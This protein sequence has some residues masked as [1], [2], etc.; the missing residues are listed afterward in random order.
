VQVDWRTDKPDH[1]YDVLMT[2]RRASGEG[3][4]FVAVGNYDQG[5]WW[6]VGGGRPERNGYKVTAWTSLP[7]PY[8]G[9]V[10]S[11]G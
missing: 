8:A 9:K 11:D 4:P 6:W 3:P 5:E 10:A 1:P 7:E 2:Y